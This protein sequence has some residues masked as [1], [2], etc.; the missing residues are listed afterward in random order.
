MSQDM[1]LE[2]SHR[3]FT[4]PLP[5]AA[6]DQTQQTLNDAIETLEKRSAQE[7]IEECSIDYRQPATR[8]LE[9]D[10]KQAIVILS[11]GSPGA[12]PSLGLLHP[13]NIELVFGKRSK[14]RLWGPDTWAAPMGKIEKTDVTSSDVTLGS[15]ILHAAER[16]FGEEISIKRT[17][18]YSMIAG[19][20][21][22]ISQGVL[23]H[24]VVKNIAE[25]VE[26]EQGV[27]IALPDTREHS[28]G[29]W[30]S[31]E[32]AVQ[33]EP[34]MPGMITALRVGLSYIKEQ[35]QMLKVSGRYHDK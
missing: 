8:S 5:D 2:K 7:S 19:S 24:V 33:A 17:G 13:K 20:F 11:L 1:P 31:L 34:M 4:Q 35:G 3:L 6:L 10:P 21:R 18:G 30:M 28:I 9:K 26:T 22:D 32:N 23:I 27:G 25:E 16:E 12:V 29:G 14:D 15:V